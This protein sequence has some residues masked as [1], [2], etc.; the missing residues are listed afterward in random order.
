M[1]LLSLSL[2]L[3]IEKTIGRWSLI[4]DF[5][6][7]PGLTD[8]PVEDAVQSRQDSM[9]LP[10]TTLTKIINSSRD[11]KLFGQSQ[12]IFS[13]FGTRKSRAP[14][15]NSTFLNMRRLLKPIIAADIGFVTK[16]SEELF[17]LVCLTF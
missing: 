15:K 11:E 3:G 17:F 6:L 1:T 4:A 12:F 2:V 14:L 16:N 5:W 8:R 10:F 13:R 9:I 7:L